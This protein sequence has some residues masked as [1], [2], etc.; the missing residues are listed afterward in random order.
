MKWRRWA[1]MLA[2]RW[3][4]QAHQ[5]PHAADIRAEALLGLVEGAQRWN[6]KRGSF[7]AVAHFYVLNRL[8]KYEREGARVVRVPHSKT[9][10]EGFTAPREC[11]M[12][13]QL[14]GPEG[15]AGGTRH[16]LLPAAP[17]PDTLE[18]EDAARLYA[19]LE[20][21]LVMHWMALPSPLPKPEAKARSYARCYV[22]WHYLGQTLEELGAQEGFTRERARQ[23]V[24]LM[25]RA[26]DR[27]AAEYRAEALGLPSPS[28][29]Q[30]A[31]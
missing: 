10:R 9:S 6:P 3:C 29:R 7:S 16:E 31:A 5:K 30:R 17:A 21:A 18:A 14:R 12:D 1:L 24:L 8:R 15:T 28:R 26:F 20:D 27:W 13:V 22:G 19:E 11:S 2:Q 4:R 23:V 25:Q